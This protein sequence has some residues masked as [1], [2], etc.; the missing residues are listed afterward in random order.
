MDKSHFLQSALWENFQKSLGKTTFRVEKP[1]FSFMATLEHT[2]VG[3]YLLVPY[4]PDIESRRFAQQAFSELEKLAREHRAIFARVEPTLPLE[5]SV[6]KKLHAKKIKDVDP[7]ETWL[8]DISDKENLNAVFPR[9]LRG[10]YNTHAEK[11]LEIVTS[12]NPDDIKHLVRLQTKTFKAK[13]ITPYSEN[14]LK[15]ELSQDFATL[16]LAKF[17]KKVI[18]AVL[19]FDD[20]TTRYYMQAASDKTYAKLNANG[21]L[22]IQSIM[23][24][25]EKGLKTYDFW[26][27]APE[28][29]GKDHPWAGFTAFKKSFHGTEIRY[30]GTYDIPYDRPRY[31]LYNFL[32]KFKK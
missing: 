6:F 12:H 14:Y 24:A 20:D 30:S 22:T 32:K 28:N 15:S 9:R 29:A 18:A 7:A 31:A 10:Y 5:P 26:G 21:V 8:V 19:V 13:N 1:H 23:D 25:A 4:G 2:P 16:Y 3:N 27:I 11:G 17:E